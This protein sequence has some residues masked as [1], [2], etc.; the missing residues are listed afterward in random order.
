MGKMGKIRKMRKRSFKSIIKNFLNNNKFLKSS[1]G[2]NFLWIIL[3]CVIIGTAIIFISGHH[4]RREL[5]SG[6]QAFVNAYGQNMD[7]VLI[8]AKQTEYQ[9]MSD[10]TILN[11]VSNSFY[12]KRDMLLSAGDIS[13]SLASLVHSNYWLDNI[14]LYSEK[15]D[16]LID[17][18]GSYSS[19]TFYAAHLSGSIDKDAFFSILHENG[20]ASYLDFGVDNSRYIAYIS[21]KREASNSYTA[22]MLLNPEKVFENFIKSNFSQYGAFALLYKDGNAFMYYDGQACTKKLDLDYGDISKNYASARSFRFEK[23]DYLIT[24]ALSSVD[25]FVYI[26]LDDYSRTGTIIWVQA[27]LI[28]ALL[29]LSIVLSSFY[30]YKNVS[31]SFRKIYDILINIQ[32]GIIPDENIIDTLEK[33][34]NALYKEKNSLETG[35]YKHRKAVISIKLERLLK[36]SSSDDAEIL[37]ELSELGIEFPNNYFLVIGF[38]IMDF[39]QIFRDVP[40]SDENLPNDY[41]LCIF[42]LENIFEELIGAKYPIYFTVSDGILAA[43]LNLPKM[44]GEITE[45]L[46]N[47]LNEGI[48]LISEQFCFRYVISL[49]NIDFGTNGINTLYKNMLLNFENIVS[50]DEKIIYTFTPR[51]GSSPGTSAGF[52]ELERRLSSAISAK[53]FDSAINTLDKISGFF[54]DNMSTM[55]ISVNIF[56][57]SSVILNALSSIMDA[58]L[59]NEITDDIIVAEKIIIPYDYFN[60]IK[61]LFSDLKE[62]YGSNEPLQINS[63]NALINK[64]HEYIL[65]NLSCTSL[66]IPMICDY[67]GQSSRSLSREYKQYTGTTISKYIQNARMTEAKRLLTETN[68]SINEISEAVGYD[69]AIS[70]IR[71]FKKFEGVT[72]SEFRNNN[73]D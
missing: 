42:I 21:H 2:L 13:Q 4:L 18:N 27:A 15:N 8:S 46:T 59:F 37:D 50:D 5:N 56:K 17:I 14:C 38:Y 47:T 67:V 31:T 62:V 40:E 72:P 70:F 23:R 73:K 60:K 36:S 11:F 63:G 6:N 9:I 35:L 20:A 16:R 49:S 3:I 33:Q 51:N 57:L 24:S 1:W 22:I 26:F 19:E 28:A 55:D 48:K 71:T 39:S 34:V 64:V 41:D 45:D 10:R 53:A 69:Y 32:Y 68:K 65:K 54:N 30:I 61:T 29:L 66:G 12:D 7:N 58:E 44:S 52:Y 43:I 25:D